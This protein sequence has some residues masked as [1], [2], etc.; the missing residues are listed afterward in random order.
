MHIEKSHYGGFRGEAGVFAALH[1]WLQAFVNEA[2][3]NRKHIMKK[4]LL[5]GYNLTDPGADNKAKPR[6]SSLARRP[7][8][9][10]EANS[11]GK[12][13]NRTNCTTTTR[14]SCIQLAGQTSFI[15]QLLI[16][17]PIITEHFA[18]RPEKHYTARAPDFL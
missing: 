18:K 11:R 2:V 1:R 10:Q 12:N 5:S 14:L 3:V 16:V 17:A 6:F 7:A 13:N 15:S 9:K 4:L 8:L